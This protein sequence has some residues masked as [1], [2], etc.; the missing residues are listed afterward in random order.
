[1][2]VYQI[3]APAF[4]GKDGHWLK[5]SFTGVAYNNESPVEEV[6]NDP[7]AFMHCQGC[8]R[9]AFWRHFK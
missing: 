2:E 7:G 9:A 5:I 4:F 6:V 8:V 3:S 1:M